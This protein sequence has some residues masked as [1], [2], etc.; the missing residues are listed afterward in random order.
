MNKVGLRAR[1]RMT[2]KFNSF[3]ECLN[4]CRGRTS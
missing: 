3:R 1:L 2:P 4:G